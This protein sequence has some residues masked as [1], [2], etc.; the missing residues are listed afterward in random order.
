MRPSWRARLTRGW[1][2]LFHS[3]DWAPNVLDDVKV[4]NRC[5]EVW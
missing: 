5:G 2:W 3:R 1:C 4:C